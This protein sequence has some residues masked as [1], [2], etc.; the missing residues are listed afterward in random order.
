MCEVEWPCPRDH[1][2]LNRQWLGPV[3]E[4]QSQLHVVRPEESELRL[5]AGGDPLKLAEK[6]Y[7][8]EQCFL[9]WEAESQALDDCTL[10]M[11][12]RFVNRA[13]DQPLVPDQA[14]LQRA[15]LSGEGAKHFSAPTFLARSGMLRS[16]AV[17]QGN[18][19]AVA[20]PLQGCRAGLAV[21]H[22]PRD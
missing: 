5:C 18:R 17:A 4:Q 14:S 12:R 2:R 6:R 8:S 7:F 15:R 21:A 19:T 10:R 22:P 1:W 11:L 3:R 13:G 16:V 9:R 20:T